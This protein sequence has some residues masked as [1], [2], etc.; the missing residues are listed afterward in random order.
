MTEADIDIKEKEEA[1]TSVADADA[2]TAPDTAGALRKFT[3]DVHFDEDYVD[4][5]D[6]P[7]AP[8]FSEDELEQAKQAAFAKGKEEGQRESRESIEKATQ[9]VVESIGGVIEQVFAQS[10]TA[11]DEIASETLV[12][13]K[14]IVAKAIPHYAGQHGLE[15]INAL[16]NQALEVAHDKPAIT[17]SV[18]ESMV[19][20]VRKAL[21]KSPQAQAYQGTV[22]VAAQSDLG[23]SDCLVRWGTEGGAQRSLAEII[24][25]VMAV[26]DRNLSADLQQAGMD[27]DPSTAETATQ[28][29]VAEMAENALENK[30]G[31]ESVS[32]DDAPE[33]T[34]EASQETSQETTTETPDEAETPPETPAQAEGSDE[35]KDETTKDQ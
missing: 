9:S 23:A 33:V 5:E 17:I 25:D 12:L 19:E 14:S 20:P 35:A 34:Q 28:E 6:I 15:E 29:D 11:L 21:E 27:S 3:F 10:R 1:Q 13:V 26:L 7:P 16:V 18:A 2:D 32:A 24:R 31:A 8:T 30:E 4:E 22:D